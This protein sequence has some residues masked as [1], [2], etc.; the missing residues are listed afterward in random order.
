MWTVHL[1][2]EWHSS[3]PLG[4]KPVKIATGDGNRGSSEQE[5]SAPTIF[6]IRQTAYRSFGDWCGIR[7]PV[8]CRAEIRNPTRSVAL[9]SGAMSCYCGR[10]GHHW[11]HMAHAQ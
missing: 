6:T 7:R 8:R 9:A 5:E 2:A 3:V 10:N 1:I 11:V 4:K